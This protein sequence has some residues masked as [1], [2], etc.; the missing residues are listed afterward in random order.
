MT[1]GALDG[2]VVADFSRVLAGPYATMMLAD[3]GAEVIKIER[4]GGGDDTRHWGPPFDVDGQA[5]YFNA[6]NR[7]KRSV[8]LDLHSAQGVEQAREI[9][10]G[11]DIVVENFRTGTM[12]RMGLGYADLVVHR[13]DLIYCSITGFGAGQGAELPGYDLLVQAVGGLMSVTG[14]QPGEPTKVGVAVVD[15]LAGLH[16]LTGILAALHHRTATGVG[17]KVETNLL[18]TL[19]SSLVNQ[20]SAY[21]GAGVVPGI[22][23]NRHPSIAPYEVF[24]TADRPLVLAVGNDKQF[25]ALC[26]ALGCESLADSASY[27]DNTARVANREALFAELTQRLRT[28]GGDEWFTVLTAAGV[29]VGPIN[30]IGQAFELAKRLELD[31][32]VD[33]PGTAVPQVANPIRLSATPVQYRSAPPPF[34]G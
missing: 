21:V 33:V 16:A 17:Q 22:M 28:R 4:P 32:V 15:V 5:T 26:V 13:P 11:A 6:V 8:V 34:G 9:V 23:G 3:L 12:E 14:P 7:N 29:P 10:R 1:P 20:A 19:L 31:A 25:R 27:A 24:S 18:S 30:D 2:V